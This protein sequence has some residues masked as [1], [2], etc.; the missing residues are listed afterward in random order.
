MFIFL[1]GQEDLILPSGILGL[2][3]VE[4]EEFKGNLAISAVSEH[5][6][7]KG[8]PR[9]DRIDT[10]EV[11]EEQRKRFARLHYH[12]DDE[13]RFCLSQDERDPAI[14]GFHDTHLGAVHVQL[15]PGELLVIPA[16]TPH[17]F[18]GSGSFLRFFSKDPYWEPHFLD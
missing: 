6:A 12:R 1:P 9:M 10:V 14:F 5:L 18:F 3:N 8:Y 2:F 16:H 4:H 13:V 17:Y 7:K 15:D 11:P